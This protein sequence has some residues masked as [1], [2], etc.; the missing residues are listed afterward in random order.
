MILS[1]KEKA[2]WSMNKLKMLTK[3]GS[4]STVYYNLKNVCRQ[5]SLVCYVKYLE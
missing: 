4:K 1:V 2:K 3:G 5:F